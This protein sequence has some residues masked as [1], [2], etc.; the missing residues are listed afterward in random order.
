MA[1]SATARTS[2]NGNRSSTISS[3]PRWGS[4][5][6]DLAAVA[7]GRAVDGETGARTRRVGGAVVERFAVAA[8]ADHGPVEAEEPGD[9]CLDASG[10]AQVPAPIPRPRMAAGA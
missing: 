7:A 4:R 6:G 1:W 3:P 2:R 10:G 5:Q 8:G 9:V